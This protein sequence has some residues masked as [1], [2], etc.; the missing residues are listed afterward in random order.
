MRGI[1]LILLLSLVGFMFFICGL[2]QLIVALKSPSP[3]RTPEQ[4]F[5]VRLL[6]N[7][8]IPSGITN[9]QAMEGSTAFGYSNGPAYIRFEAS[10][11]VMSQLIE[12]DYGIFGVYEPTPC[13]N[14]PFDDNQVGTFSAAARWWKPSKL[15]SPT[16]YYAQTCMIYDEKYLLIDIEESIGYFY[17]TPVCGLCPSGVQGQELRER[18]R[19]RGSY[20]SSK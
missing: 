8:P 16:C 20:T 15:P 6:D 10:D 11:D 12:I 18:P 13:E 7:H 19:C 17:R 1:P 14:S 9:I 3:K 5:S 2:P 4:I